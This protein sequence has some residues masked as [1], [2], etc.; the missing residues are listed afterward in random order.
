MKKYLKKIILSFPGSILPAIFTL[1]YSFKVKFKLKKIAQEKKLEL[2]DINEFKL[3]LNR[4][5]FILG[6]G[7]SINELTK[8]EKKFIDSSTSVGLNLIIL[9]DLNPKFLTLEQDIN[10]PLYFKA[11][12]K[13]N[14]DFFN[15][16]PNLL[17]VDSFFYKDENIY[18]LKK[19]FN[20]IKI[21][22]IARILFLNKS[23]FQ[24]IY[25][26]LFHPLFLKLLGRGLIYGRSSTVDRIIS[27]AIAAGFKEIVFVG[28]DLHHSK[29]FWE[30]LKFEDDIE[31]ELKN[32]V[33][34]D[35]T[36]PHKTEGE[37]E[38]PASEFIK[39]ANNFVT[40]KSV[41]F[42][43]TSKNSKLY[44]FLPKYKFP[45]V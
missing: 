43:T 6:N 14:H 41:K 5:F 15:K 45:K 44:S 12:E 1:I 26:Y 4:P 35:P 21:Y 30:D 7:T 8:D 42:Y 20:N 22:A 40:K 18:L 10:V 38:I 33:S 25:N 32:E 29:A 16:N 3:N 36:K 37:R 28:V 23:N 17:I 24:G 19:Y 11:L 13:K 27:I 39:L 2:L 31:T 34:K 9:S